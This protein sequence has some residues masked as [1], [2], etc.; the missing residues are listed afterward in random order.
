MQL[1][2]FFKY[3]EIFIGG[4]FKGLA[5]LKRRRFLCTTERN[6]KLFACSKR[7]RG[8]L[9]AKSVPID[10]VQ[11]PYSRLEN[12]AYAGNRENVPRLFKNVQ[13][14][15]ANQRRGRKPAVSVTR[16]PR[17]LLV[18][19]FRTCWRAAAMIRALAPTKGLVHSLTSPPGRAEPAP[20]APTSAAV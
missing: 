7:M 6:L 16:R 5:K 20:R 11:S 8:D 10:N 19:L 4:V 3:A 18:S 9:V 12:K 13:C 14:G 1:A 15:G 2:Y 17:V